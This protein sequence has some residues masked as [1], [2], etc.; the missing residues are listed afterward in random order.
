MAGT[1]IFAFSGDRPGL[2]FGIEAWPASQAMGK[3]REWWRTDGSPLDDEGKDYF[4]CLLNDGKVDFED[5]WMKLFK[6]PVE[7]CQWLFEEAG[8]IQADYDYDCAAYCV[9][10]AEAQVAKQQLESLRAALRDA[11]G[12][13]A[14]AIRT[15][16][17]KLGGGS[18]E[19]AADR[20]PPPVGPI[21]DSAGEPSV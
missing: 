16:V 4:D 13:S 14:D 11:L 8:R 12:T 9:E 6:D 1:Y 17:S 3:F 7:A 10:I 15:S 2:R 5:G 21:P 20:A 18:V 19:P